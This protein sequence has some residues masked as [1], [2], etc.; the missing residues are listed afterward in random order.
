VLAY[1]PLR[2]DRYRS[3]ASGLHPTPSRKPPGLSPETSALGSRRGMRSP[4]HMSSVSTRC[5]PRPGRA[6]AT[7]LGHAVLVF[8]HRR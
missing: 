6:Y 2:R 1:R 5:P 8:Y 3:L 7:A 4:S